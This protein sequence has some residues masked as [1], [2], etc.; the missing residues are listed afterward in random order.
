VLPDWSLPSGGIHLVYP[1]TR[2]PAGKVRRFIDFFRDW[3][4]TG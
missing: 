2:Q 4:A 3:Q 1:A